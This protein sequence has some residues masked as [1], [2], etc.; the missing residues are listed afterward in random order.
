MN[1]QPDKTYK[2][3]WSSFRAVID[4]ARLNSNL[5]IGEKNLTKE[6]IDYFYKHHVAFSKNCPSTVRKIRGALQYYINRVEY[7]DH[8]ENR[9]VIGSSTIDD[10][11][12]HQQGRYTEASLISSVDPHAKIP[13]NTL[14]NEDHVKAMST[15][16]N[17]SISYWKSLSLSWTLGTACLIRPDTFIK[18][19]LTS[20]YLDTRHIPPSGD[21]FTVSYALYPSDLKGGRNNGKGVIRVVGSWRHKEYKRCAVGYLA[22]ILFVSLRIVSLRNDTKLNFYIDGRRNGTRMVGSPPS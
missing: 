5:P 9:F 18:L 8:P 16:F 12:L 14:T 6:N 19:R 21:K 22:M 15:L 10:A 11:L 20:I 17:S 3:I 13:T 7:F 1:H 4:S 2:S